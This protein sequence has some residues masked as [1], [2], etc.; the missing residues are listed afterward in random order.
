MTATMALQH[1]KAASAIAMSYLSVIWGVLID[2]VVYK[3]LPGILTLLGASLI[4]ACS[5][6]VSFYERRCAERFA[7]A[8]V[9]LNAC[10]FA[11]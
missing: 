8:V 3:K 11:C 7:S 9:C 1:T 4:C 5:L 6:V 2:T 10:L